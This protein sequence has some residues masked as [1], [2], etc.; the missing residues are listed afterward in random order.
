LLPNACPDAL[1]TSGRIGLQC[2]SGRIEFRRIEVK[3]VN[4]ATKVTKM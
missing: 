2:E 1:R 3:V 4:S